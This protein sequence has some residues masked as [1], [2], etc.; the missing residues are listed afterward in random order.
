VCDKIDD[1]AL[2]ELKRFVYE[3]GCANGLLFD[4]LTYLSSFDVP[5]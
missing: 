1:Q 5:P 3:Y 4:G 2:E